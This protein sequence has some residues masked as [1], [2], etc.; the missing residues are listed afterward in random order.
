MTAPAIAR[1]L[2]NG[3]VAA[4][5]AATEEPYPP[6]SLWKGVKWSLAYVGFLA[7]IFV[8]TT[9][10]L[11]LGTEAMGLALAALPLEKG[12]FRLPGIALWCL[13][14][15]LWASTGL[16]TSQY[17]DI[18]WDALIEYGKICLIVVA[19]EN[20]IRSRSRLRLFLVL[21]LAFF[22]FFPVRGALFN[23]FIYGEKAGG[24]AIWNKIYSNPNDLG[25]FCL[26]QL[27]LAIGI[28]YTE[29]KGIVRYAAILGLMVVPFLLLLTQSRG[30]FIGGALFLVV[31]LRTQKKV[32]RFIGIG[33]LAGSIIFAFTPASVWQRLGTLQTVA[34]DDLNETNDKG[35]ARQ[36]Y[37]IWKVA[38]TIAAEHPVFGIGLGTYQ[39]VHKI[40]AMRPEFDPT[41]RGPRD[42]HSTYL[43]LLAE[44]GAIGLAFFM[45][46]VISTL[47]KAERVRRRAA[48]RL[49]RASM[50]LL[51][52]EVGLVAFLISG[53]FG[54]YPFIVFTYVHIVIITAATRLLEDELRHLP[55]AGRPVAL[56]A[57]PAATPAAAA[58]AAAAPA[59]RP[60]GEI[61]RAP[62]PVDWSYR[63]GGPR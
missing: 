50:Q 35:S 24:R 59:Q 7:Y 51:Y 27:S 3:V 45:G 41:A 58:P 28:V 20:T 38:R 4:S 42:T 15:L 10:R 43:N 23:F 40:Y 29:R 47:V 12:R 19:A 60:L 18:V 49:Y 63:H 5:P 44:V 22:A 2:P 8:V 6:A 62:V 9:Y 11:P 39:T 14:L 25:A 48:K 34:Q 54:T 30:A 21:F 31:A 37:E 32:F 53:I 16:V 46:L 61:H 52:L 33:A 13:L 56:G 57:A 26:L 36:R 55:P 1:I 17:P